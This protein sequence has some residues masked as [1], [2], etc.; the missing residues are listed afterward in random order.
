MS[1]LESLKKIGSKFLT[2]IILIII[3]FIIFNIYKSINANYQ[4]SSQISNIED[5]IN[6]IKKKNIYLENLTLY[7]QTD[8][9]REL[10]LRRKLNLKKPDEKIVIVAENTSIKQQTENYSTESSDNE[11]KKD[12]EANYKKWW[13]YLFNH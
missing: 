4:I 1:K 6:T 5:E 9:F 7:Y 3:G 11:T 8:T 12:W 10:E 13:Q 2:L